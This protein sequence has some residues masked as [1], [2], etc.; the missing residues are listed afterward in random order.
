MLDEPKRQYL[1][2][3]PTFGLDRIFGAFVLFKVLS[4]F[5][6][7]VGKVL[8][9]FPEALGPLRGQADRATV[10]S[11]REAVFKTAKPSPGCLCWGND[12]KHDENVTHLQA[13]ESCILATI[14]SKHGTSGGAQVLNHLLC[15][16][17]YDILRR[18]Y[19]GTRSCQA[20]SG[21]INLATHVQDCFLIS[22]NAM[23]R[24]P[25]HNSG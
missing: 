2:A 6:Y 17:K 19:Q 14:P 5:G 25:K 13:V 7:H 21:S 15:S 4:N 10:V 22:I 1:D 24:S 11:R 16:M 3:M 20:Q 9:T 12:A 23:V 8:V 18:Q